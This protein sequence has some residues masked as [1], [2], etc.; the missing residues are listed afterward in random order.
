MKKNKIAILVI[1]VLIILSVVL[2]V[3]SKN[4]FKTADS[5]LNTFQSFDYGFSLVVPEG[6]TPSQFDEFGGHTILIQNPDYQM[7]I[8]ITLFDEDISL[9]QERIEYDIPDMKMENSEEI[10]IDSVNAVS[11]LSDDNGQKYRQIWFVH[12]GYLY[13]ILSPASADDIT[14]EL[15]QVW[16]WFSL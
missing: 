9:T 5:P 7:Q 16:K 10:K 11:F 3:G 6:I 14:N 15:M 12:G 13:Q 4:N 8:Y 1:F 2:F